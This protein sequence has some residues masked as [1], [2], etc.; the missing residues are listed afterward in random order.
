MSIIAIREKIAEKMSKP[1]PPPAWVKA[2]AE[3]IRARI[4]MGRIEPKKGM[5]P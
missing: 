1:V 3:E 2:K 5:K 4:A